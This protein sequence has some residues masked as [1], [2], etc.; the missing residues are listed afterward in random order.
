MQQKKIPVFNENF[1][2]L[3]FLFIVKK[4]IWIVATIFMICFFAAYAYLRYTPSVYSASSV[5]QINNGSETDKILNIQ[6]VYGNTEDMSPV[7]ELLRSN[8]FLKRTFT[9]LPL[10]I[11]YYLEG[12][13]LSS[14][15]Y[16]TTPYLVEIKDN[17]SAI[18]YIPFYVY[19]SNKN[20]YTLTYNLG[21]TEKEFHYKVDQWNMVEG[22]EIKLSIIDFNT[23]NLSQGNIKNNNFFF[24]VKQLDNILSENVP[25]LQISLLNESAK[26][27]QI[28]YT[29]NNAA[30]ACEI[31]N[32]ISEDFLK[33]D[34]EKKRES[35]NQIL[36]FIDEQLGFII[37]KMDETEGQLQTYKK[38]NKVPAQNDNENKSTVLIDYQDK[39]EVFEESVMKIQIELMTLQN[40]EK[41]ITSNKNLNIYE[42]IALLTGTQSEG[43]LVNILNGLQDLLNKRE[44]LLN[45]VTGNNHQIKVLDKQVANQKQILTEFVRST[46][47]RLTNIKNDYNTKII[48]YESK[49]FNVNTTDELEFIKLNREYT[50]NQGFYDQLIQKKAEY[51]VSQAGYVSKNVILEK[52]VTPTIPIYPSKNKVL[53]VYVFISIFLSLLI[54]LIRYLLHD[55]IT[56][57]A[58][59]RLYTQVPIVGTV[60]NY[61]HKLSVSTLVVHRNPKS[62]ISEAF[63]TIKSNLEFISI[64]DY[65]QVI[66]IS[67]TVSGE[68]KTFMSINLAG[69]TAISG[70]KVILIDMDLRKP[71]IHLSFNANNDLGMSNLLIKKAT[72][73][74]CI[75][76]SELKCLDFITAGPIPPNPS[77]LANGIVFDELI[78]D[79]KKN[80][81]VIIIDT[82]PIGLVTDGITIFKKADYP[83]YVMRADY[84]KRTYLHKVNEL[85]TEKEIKRLSIILNNIESESTK[86]GYGYGYG[87]DYGH[88]YYEEQDVKIKKISFLKRFSR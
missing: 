32:T 15:L 84:S 5:I 71:K 67:S 56:T 13:F 51:M 35:A 83:I 59:V 36:K 6:S 43:V 26:T 81:D 21:G 82:P 40:I 57:D 25:N 31:V 33:Y 63:R 29:S 78:L 54:I 1:D 41:E 28:S 48:E 24:V 20:E 38:L 2:L 16:K 72:Y 55:K 42:L 73:D 61:K 30:K 17:A 8:E 39:I 50:I 62:V 76:K 75:K 14:E 3:L 27:I 49:I 68:G 79:L 74:Q 70:K 53:F 69:I 22:V 34:I 23:I 58:D 77:E 66:A 47:K 7:I 10:N 4:S 65:P 64:Q 52:S 37:K 80:Y 87:Y 18:T 85:I 11:G 9:N 88:S 45:D 44:Q 12:T 60:P 19:F 46:I 86:Y